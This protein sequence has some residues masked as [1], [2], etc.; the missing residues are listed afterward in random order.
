MSIKI[1]NDVKLITVQNILNNVVTLKEAAR[2]LGVAYQSIQRWISIYKGFGAEGFSIKSGN[3]RYTPELK[4]QAV[5]EYL[6]GSSSLMDICIKYKIR[7]NK[8]LLDWI[9]KYNG[10]NKTK[11]SE[12]GGINIITKGRATTYEERIEIIKYCIENNNNYAETE[13]I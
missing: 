10:H 13:K 5:T 1:S 4:Q 6:H 12:T 7:S 2:S 11:I 8:Q 9:L 3:N